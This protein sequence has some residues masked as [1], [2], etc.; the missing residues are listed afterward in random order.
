MMI[1]RLKSA[2]LLACALF[3]FASCSLLTPPQR[4][5]KQDQAAIDQALAR[6]EGFKVDAVTLDY[7]ARCKAR[8]KTLEKAYS[9]SC[10]LVLTRDHRLHLSVQNPLGGTLMSVYADSHI[11]HVNDFSKKTSY[12]LSPE[13]SQKMEIPVI[14]FLTIA[15]LQAILWGRL[16]QGIFDT[17][18]YELDSGRPLAVF[19]RQGAANLTVRYLRWMTYQ[20]QEF[21]RIIDMVDKRNG[22][23][24]K[25]AITEFKP[26]YVC[27][28][29]D[30]TVFPLR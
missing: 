16:P 26:G 11:I 29:N 17:L 18:G 13:E 10:R 20:E 3:L 14:P 5:E 30:K 1:N 8:I 21:P 19:K 7:V 12:R 6:L 25:L 4:C 2:L 15:E 23:S 27:D 22:D 24:I 28:L 9:G